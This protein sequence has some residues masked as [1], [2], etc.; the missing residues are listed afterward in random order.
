MPFAE[1]LPSPRVLNLA[2][3]IAGGALLGY[4]YFVQFGLGIEPCPLCI[5]Q[6]IALIALTLVFLGAAAQGATGKGRLAWAALVAVVAGAG[7]AVAGRHV[8]LQ[9]LPPDLVPA[10]GPGLNY[11]IDALPLFDA[12]AEA[13]HGSGEC[14]KVDWT[15]LGLAMPAWTLL[16]FSVL[17]VGGFLNNLRRATRA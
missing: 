16:W 17:G 6:R 9:S 10:C 3:A 7:I 8:W 1:K 12:L 11:L 2:A 14:A 15:F 4:A 13:F 5:M